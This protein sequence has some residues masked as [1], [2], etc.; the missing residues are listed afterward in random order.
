MN[1]TFIGGGNMATALISGLIDRGTR[2]EE[3]KVVEVD[4]AARERLTQKMGVICFGTNELSAIED[5]R[6]IVLAV[7]P[8]HLRAVA[9]QLAP[10]LER[11]IVISIAAGVRLT[12]LARLG[13]KGVLVR[14]M[15]NT[16]A[17]IGK[18]IT[19]LYSFPSR[20]G[21]APADVLAVE[22]VIHSI[23]EFVWVTDEEK[24]N[25][26]TAISGSGPAYVFLFIEA[27]EQAALELGMPAEIA[28]KLAVA[29]FTG[30][31]EL[32][33]Q[34][35]EPV[36]ELR[37]RVTSKGGT[38]EAALASMERDHIKDAIIRAI[39]SA[40]ARSRELGDEF[41]QA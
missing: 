34:S 33:A 14:A 24:M 7:K 40:A 5:A 41:D 9:V 1:I 8:K 22:D 35:S 17:Q 25:A 16:P 27:L 2:P 30:A 12:D 18:G 29:T 36:S 32:A 37:A 10:L 13:I 21:L 6:V 11:Q 28:R 31:A 19:G 20:D 26:V 39:K 15:P 3:I 38:T 4:S 23:G